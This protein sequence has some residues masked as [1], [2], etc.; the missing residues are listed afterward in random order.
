MLG[1]GKDSTTHIV[2]YD[3]NTHEICEVQTEK[4]LADAFYNRNCYGALYGVKQK[5]EEKHQPN[6]DFDHSVDRT[7]LINRHQSQF[8]GEDLLSRFHLTINTCDSSDSEVNDDDQLD[9]LQLLLYL[10]QH[11][12]WDSNNKLVD[13]NFD[14]HD[15][16]TNP[17]LGYRKHLMKQME[18]DA[19]T[20]LFRMISAEDHFIDNICI[21]Q[22]FTSY[23][24][25]KV[26]NLIRVYNHLLFD[27]DTHQMTVERL[28][29][30]QSSNLNSDSLLYDC[31]ETL[32]QSVPVENPISFYR[33]NIEHLARETKGFNHAA[34]QCR[35]PDAEINQFSFLD[36]TQLSH[37]HLAVAQNS[38]H[39]FVLATY[40]GIAAI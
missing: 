11:A 10:R 23:K 22:M 4:V 15:A 13:H 24:F 40:G 5:D 31:V 29:D 7:Y 2:R 20:S 35:F 8:I 18:Q 32:Q 33:V 38:D 39:V 26:R 9:E 37:V 1:H 30:V 34:C 6:I 27:F 21:C 16:S 14:Y 3:R 36:Y 12:W 19:G 17:E 28:P 25:N